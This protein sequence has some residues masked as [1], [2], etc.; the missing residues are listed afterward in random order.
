[1]LPPQVWTRGAG[2]QK[3]IGVSIFKQL[4]RQ[5]ARLKGVDFDALEQLVLL[6]AVAQNTGTKGEANRFFDDKT[7]WTGAA[8]RG[9]PDRAVDGA[10]DLAGLCNTGR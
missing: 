5:I 3:K 9:G 4:L 2:S 10:T 1:M 8:T 6:N 7:T